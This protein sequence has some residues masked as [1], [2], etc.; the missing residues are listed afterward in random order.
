M[1]NIYKNKSNHQYR[2]A[3]V[4]REDRTQYYFKYRKITNEDIQKVQYLQGLRTQ[5]QEFIIATTDQFDFQILSLSINIEN[6]KYKILDSYT[7]DQINTTGLFRQGQ[8]TTYLRIG[9]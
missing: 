6:T 5:A 2:T 4:I 8:R 3:A 9:N 7:E 1:L